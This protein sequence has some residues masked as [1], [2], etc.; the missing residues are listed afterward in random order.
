MIENDEDKE[1]QC[2]NQIKNANTDSKQKVLTAEDILKSTTSC[3]DL[4]F[5]PSTDGNPAP[6]FGTELA[7]MSLLPPQKCASIITAEQVH[8]LVDKSEFPP[9]RKSQIT[10]IC[11]DQMIL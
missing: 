5:E 1:N 4:L 6:V 8:N 10:L 11:S 7:L 2:R 3:F 9:S